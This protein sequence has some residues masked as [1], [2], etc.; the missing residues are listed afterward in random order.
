MD[1]Y[2][3]TVAALCRAC[4]VA[5]VL[6]IAASV[7]IVCQMVVWRYGFGRP[8]VWQTEVVIYA[9]VATTLIGSPYVLWRRG[10]VNM[11]IVVLY[12]GPRLRRRMAIAAAVI[13]LAFCALLTVYGAHFWF[14]A[15]SKGWRS[16]TLTRIPLWIP[17]LALP[18]GMGIMSLQLVAEL[19]GLLTGRA[20]PF[21]LPPRVGPAAVL[22]H[23]G[24]QGR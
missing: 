7:V 23:D 3:R 13:S 19:L 17:Y 10:H 9:L 1:A 2:V 12:A 11:D 21:G 4:G 22:G 20:L 24:E 14:E 18:L 6:L 5:A 8:T 15:W 16:D